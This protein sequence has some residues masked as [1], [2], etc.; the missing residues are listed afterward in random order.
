MEETPLTDSGHTPDAWN[1]FL[2]A[3]DAGGVVEIDQGIFNYFLDVLPPVYMGRI[4]EVGGVMRRVSFGFAE[5]AE[6]ITAF[7]KEG[8]RFFCQRTK[9]MNR[10]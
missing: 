3:R 2:A 10:G 8:G 7:W 4:V 1:Q 5:G 6:T 9:D